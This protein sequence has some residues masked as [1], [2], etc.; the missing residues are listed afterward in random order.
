MPLP[1]TFADKGG[2][3]VSWFLTFSYEQCWTTLFLL[4]LFVSTL[5]AVYHVESIVIHI[6]FS[7]MIPVPISII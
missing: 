6:Q 2:K 4:T 1:L 3:R 7:G 5:I